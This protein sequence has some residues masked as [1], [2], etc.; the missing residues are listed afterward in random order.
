MDKVHWESIKLREAVASKKGKKPIRLETKEFDDSLPYIN[1]EAF[2]TGKINQYADKKSST[3][4]KTTDIMVVWDGA[5]FGLAGTNQQGA[6][7]STIMCLTPTKVLSSYL[8]NFI[9]LNYNT[10][11]Q[12]PKGMATPHVNPDIFWNLEIPIS[13][14]DEQQQI[15]E[16]LDAILP[17]IRQVK[18]RMENIPKLLK[19]FRQS[20]ISDACSGKLTRIRESELDKARDRFKLE[21]ICDITSGQAFHSRDFIKSGV[22]VIKIANVQYG[23]YSDD[24]NQDFLPHEYKKSYSKYVVQAYDILL[25]LTRPITNDTLKACIYPDGREKA[26][27]NQR[28]AMLKPQAAISREYLM[29]AVQSSDFKESIRSNLSETLQPNLSP[30]NLAQIYIQCPSLP[31]QREIVH[32]VEKLFV[33]ADSLEAKYKQAMQSIGKIE[34]SVLAKA[35][36][37]E[38]HSI[39]E[40]DIV[41]DL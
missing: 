13:S 34:Q 1:I 3:H 41:G 30:K 38:L 18:S 16:K 8:Y 20:L 24:N 23:Y 36:R 17:R 22:P 5:R 25:A 39:E 9:K 21:E 4:C 14:I 10:I 2:E 19:K 40:I 11:Q 28:V 33:L 15:V 29:L 31:E 7:G 27:L 32:Q 35:F 26:L 12:N 37:G 6:V